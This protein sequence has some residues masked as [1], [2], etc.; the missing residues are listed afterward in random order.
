L[1]HVN[2]HD[3]NFYLISIQLVAQDDELVYHIM[4]DINYVSNLVN[5]C[6]DITGVTSYPLPMSSWDDKFIATFFVEVVGSGD[7]DPLRI[8]AV[9][10]KSFEIGNL[11]FRFRIIEGGATRGAS[12]N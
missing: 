6:S 7:D 10:E 9:F 1:F 11:E 5:E 12:N 3:T 8:R 2:E 4:E